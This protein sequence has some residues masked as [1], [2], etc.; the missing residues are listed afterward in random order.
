MPKAV[1]RA[2]EINTLSLPFYIAD[3]AWKSPD[4]STELKPLRERPLANQ[5]Q[6]FLVTVTKD[7][8]CGAV[9]CYHPDLHAAEISVARE[10]ARLAAA[11]PL[12]ISA[13][14]IDAWVNI[15]EEQTSEP[16]R[17]LPC[18]FRPQG[19]DA[20]RSMATQ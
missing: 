16:F 17:S 3:P 4:P 19:L 11:R 13:Q 1:I 8:W 14:K 7:N 10:L 18:S 20:S 12:N 5:S 2:L 9:R 6:R 15:N